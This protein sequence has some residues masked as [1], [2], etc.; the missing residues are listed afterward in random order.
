MAENQMFDNLLKLL[1]DTGRLK[2]KRKTTPSTPE[3]TNECGGK[4]SVDALLQSDD[5]I[6]ESDESMHASP[7]N[8]SSDEINTFNLDY[9]A[10]ESLTKPE[11]EEVD[12]DL[13]YFVKYKTKKPSP[14]LKKVIQLKH[15]PPVMSNAGAYGISSTVAKRLKLLVD[16]GKLRRIPKNV[17]YLFYCMNSYLDTL[18]IN[19]IVNQIS[20]VRFVC[21]LHA[22]NH[23]IKHADNSLK[24]PDIKCQGLTRPKVL[25]LCGLRSIAK[26][27]IDYILQLA[28]VSKKAEKVEKY[29]NAF[30]L[31]S[32]D[33][34]EQ[35]ESFIK[36]KKPLDYVLTFTG[37]QDDAF[38]IGLRYQS[39]L[40]HLY[41]PF[42]SSDIIVAS[43]L[44]LKAIG[45]EERDYDFLS[46]IEV[47]ICDRA[48]IIKYQNWKFLTDI[49]DLLN[50]PLNT[51]R[52]ADINKI[53]SSAIDYK[54]EKYRQNILVSCIQS[55]IFN[56]FTRTFQ[57]RRGFIKLTKRYET[58]YAI[59]G[60]KLKIQ[61]LFI[62]VGCTS[63]QDSDEV[64]Y[65]ECYIIQALINYFMS[66]MIN[67]LSG[68]GGV[69]LV[70]KDH[71]Q[72]LK[73]VNFTC[74][75]FRMYKQLEESNL[76]YLPCHEATRDKK[77]VF[78]RQQ[79]QAGVFF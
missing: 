56:A 79:F 8:I 14:I 1:E 70:V 59:L 37:N 25:I 60:S 9:D 32:T 58:D 72:F 21:A 75:N 6:S 66:N 71:T 54:M 65:F 68:V 57:N 63:I 62:K 78:A 4:D 47:L 55:V 27:I 19:P 12:V 23:V 61:Q 16:E 28:P 44:G 51:W 20:A 45:D 64:C 46:S 41:S 31:D 15:V 18:Y 26:E 34:M 38:K 76:P 7:D 13:P 36:T 35:Q 39:G 22:V 67:N 43:P 10:Y 52:D 77:M 11:E 24:S 5:E 48:D 74:K 73:F 33:L 40:I 29:E 50:Q 17:N 3:S 30:S 69:L 2:K 53:R 42:Y 49:W